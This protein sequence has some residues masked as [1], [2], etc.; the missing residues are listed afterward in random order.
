MAILTDEAKR[1][2]GEVS[3]ALVATAKSLEHD[4][5]HRTPVK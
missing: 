2:I 1:I 3:P 4:F 5:G